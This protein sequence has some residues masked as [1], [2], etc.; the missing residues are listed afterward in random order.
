MD[1]T[2]TGKDIIKAMNWRYAGKIFD[3]TKIITDEELHT[4]LEAG[5]LSPSVFGLEPWQFILVNNKDTRKKLR[6]ASYGQ[7]KVTDASHLVI[8][9]TRTDPTNVVDEHVKRT[10]DSQG[11]TVEDLKGFNDMLL[12]ALTQ[13]GD[14]AVN[15]LTRQSY[16]PLGIMIE[17]AA[18]LGIDSGPMEGFNA[19]QV[20]EILGLKE[21]NLHA[22]TILALGHRGDDPY[23]KVPKVRKSFEEAVTMI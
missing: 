10:A 3:A 13:H 22:T 23:L 4:V 16:I 12:G 11:K 14:K 6:E 19:D 15:W 9:A 1:T 18:L 17:T 2:T 8:I 21:K 7:P 20:D 5:R